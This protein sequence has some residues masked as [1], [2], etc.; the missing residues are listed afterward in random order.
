MEECPKC[1]W[2][3]FN[4]KIRRPDTI[5]PSLPSGIDKILKEHFDKF[6]DRGE[7]PP[8][9][10]ERDDFRGCTLFADAELLKEWRNNFKERLD[11]AQRNVYD[12]NIH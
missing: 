5:F 1:F 11:R 6:R 9:L 12:I 8:E 7:L 4:K 10:K 2:L 3:H